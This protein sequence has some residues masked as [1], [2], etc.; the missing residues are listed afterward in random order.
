MASAGVASVGVAGALGLAVAS[1]VASAEAF[2]FLGM[3]KDALRSWL[4][5]RA[6]D[7][8]DEVMDLLTHGQR[9]FMV[10]GFQP[11]GFAGIKNGSKY[12]AHRRIFEKN[13]ADLHKANK[14]ILIRKSVMKEGDLKQLNGSILLPVEKDNGRSCPRIVTHMSHGTKGH[15]SYNDSV[16]MVRHLQVYKRRRLPMARDFADLLCDMW[17]HFPDAKFLHAAVI[18]AASAFETYPLSFDKCKLV[19][20]LMDIMKDG[21]VVQVYKGAVAGMFGDRG[22]GDTWDI[23]GDLC[24]ALHN[25][26]S[27]LFKSKTYVDDLGAFAPPVPSDVDP[28]TPRW[29]YH[30]TADVIPS[31]LPGCELHPGTRYA[32]MDAVVEARDNLAR[33]AGP[34]S[35]KLK[36]VKIYSGYTELLGWYMD[37]RYSH[38]YMSP[39]RSKLDKLAHYL[40][41]LVPAGVSKATYKIMQS[42][43][44]LLCWFSQALPLG[45]SFVYSLF[46]CERCGQNLV[47]LSK[48]AQRDLDFWRAMIRVALEEPVLVG[49]P[50][51]L[52]RTTCVP[53]T[54]IVT[55][56]CTGVGAGGWISNTPSWS[57]DSDKWWFILRWT[58]QELAAIQSRLT[59]IPPP[60]D[61]D[62]RAMV[63]KA[64]RS[65]M[66]PDT[67]QYEVPLPKLTINVL[68]FATPV[69]LIMVCAPFLKGQVVSIGVDNTAALCWLVHH[70]SSSGVADN[71][72]KLL[73]LTCALY[74][75]RI[76]AHHVKGIV[77]Y[78]SDWKS[79]VQGVERCDP[80]EHLLNAQTASF[81]LALQAITRTAT[82][83]RRLAVRQLLSLVLLN[84]EPMDTVTLITTMF[85][86][87]TTC[88]PNMVEDVQIKK[89]LDSFQR[90]HNKHG[91]PP[92]PTIPNN[93]DDA[94]NMCDVWDRL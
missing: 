43:T 70:K 46:Q 82:T 91:V 15:P 55:D 7:R 25:T 9:A 86:L 75:I 23:L 49:C 14:A 79:R 6:P 66:V 19:W 85:S 76:V 17:E 87:R 83:D 58:P 72:L 56:A 37:L 73:A 52:L 47:T 77:N 33:L 94:V 39:L 16:D 28:L 63:E 69:F 62:D 64:V 74:N 8:A 60:A 50:I 92:V 57:P 89:V 93:I 5:E 38:F 54:Y 24:D 35:T 41:N 65:Y 18:D 10:E 80:H 30:D 88:D 45:K 20:S 26:A 68:E 59:N 78:L 40:F 44:G 48:T 2:S 51:A 4:V 1:A 67:V 3:P 42:L 84:D 21:E 34:N 13:A 29:H 71:L 27:N 53:S 81:P 12:E 11:N 31:A 22:A 36:K 61:D 90:F 32:I